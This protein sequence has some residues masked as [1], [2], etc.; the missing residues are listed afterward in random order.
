M[1]MP[2]SRDVVKCVTGYPFTQHSAAI[3][4]TGWLSELPCGKIGYTV[5]NSKAKCRTAYREHASHVWG[6]HLYLLLREYTSCK[7]AGENTDW[8]RRGSCA[9]GGRRGRETLNVLCM[10]VCVCFWSAYIYTLFGK[11]PERGMRK[12]NTSMP[13]GAV[14]APPP[15]P[16][17][18]T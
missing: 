8:G 15:R 6:K 1:R 7:I 2:I 4:R 12:K 17:W 10:C 11:K 3:N 16:W 14:A 18:L 5:N 13:G 9:N